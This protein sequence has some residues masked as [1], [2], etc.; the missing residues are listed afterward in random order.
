MDLKITFDFQKN[1]GI[2]E[3][4]K[5]I[6]EPIIKDINP[7]ESQTCRFYKTIYIEYFIQLMYDIQDN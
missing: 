2:I 6:Q 7:N 1:K 3:D 5:G 4:A